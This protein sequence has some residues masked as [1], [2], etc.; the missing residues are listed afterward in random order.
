MSTLIPE[1]ELEDF[2]RLAA[3]D[4]K[5]LQCCEVYSD[6]AYVCTLTIPGTDYIRA[7]AENNG[8]ISN[9]VAGENPEQVIRETTVAMPSLE[10]LKAK[11]SATVA[12]GG[13]KEK[14]KYKKHKHRAKKVKVL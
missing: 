2:Q 3:A 7:M 5:R 9:S 6:G 10:P 13:A 11:V 1:I 14:R 4:I 12:I 8:Q